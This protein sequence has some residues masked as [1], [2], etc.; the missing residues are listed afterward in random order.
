MSTRIS[1]ILSLRRTPL[2]RLMQI[3]VMV[4][5]SCNNLAPQLVALL[6]LS[7]LDFGLFSLGYLTFSLA[8]SVALSSISEAYA[9]AEGECQSELEPENYSA[10][11]TWLSV[12]FGLVAGSVFL[13]LSG[14]FLTALLSS[15]SVGSASRRSP[16]RYLELR[17][18]SWRRLLFV[19]SIALVTFIA[20]LGVTFARL[21]LLD[22][23]LFAWASA[24]VAQW[25]L[26]SMRSPGS[27]R[28]AIR[29][30]REHKREIRPLLG[31]S[32][33]LDVSAIGTPYMLAPILGTM[34]FGIYRAVSNFN[35][36]LRIVLNFLR[37]HLAK[38]SLERA[39]SPS[40][41]LRF[42]GLSF[43]WG[44]VFA[45][46]LAYVERNDSGIAML[47]A[48]SPYWL[49]TGIYMMFEATLQ[50]FYI[51]AR[52]K[53]VPKGIWLGRLCQSFVAIVL[54][55]TGALLAD[56]V[57]AIWGAALAAIL[58]SLVWLYIVQFEA[59]GDKLRQG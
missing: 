57:G 17:S 5:I 24:G 34:S 19:E 31:E 36:P 41:L 53:V 25:V 30:V 8:V 9:R 27:L 47:D 46:T 7:P 10:I 45:S 56:L 42:G 3:V 49:P 23:V 37:P 52:T 43:A 50:Y 18:K 58:G 26:G 15:I 28:A 59:R 11:S 48:L 14:S 22:A 54:P 39:L 6:L 33:I 21:Q 35:A 13:I 20:G 51:V 38:T 32:L 4:I 29:W 44:V 55:I 12:F 40:L 1:S 16:I 2:K